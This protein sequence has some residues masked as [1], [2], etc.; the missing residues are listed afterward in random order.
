[1]QISHE[2]E[3]VIEDSN[4]I[5]LLFEKGSQLIK[6]FS[7]DEVFDFSLGNPVFEPPVEV[8]N[9]LLSLIDSNER[10]MHRYMPNQGIV[11]TRSYIA[12][13]LLKKTKLNFTENEV[14]ITTGAAGALNVLFKAICNPGDEVIVF[15]PYFIDYK[16]YVQNA[17]GKLKVVY[18]KSDF[19][20]DLEA[21]EKSINKMTK[22]VLINSPNNPTG[23]IYPKSD[24]DKMGEILEQKSKEYGNDIYLIS[25]S[26][27][28]KIVYDNI[29]VPSIFNSYKNSI[30][31][32]SYSKSLAIPGERIGH[33]AISPEM[34]DTQ[35]FMQALVISQRILG[36]VN[37][38][39]LFQRLIPK[40]QDVSVDLSIYKENRDELY[41]CITSLG[42]ECNKAAGAFYLFPKSPI[43]DDVEFVTEAQK[44]N[45]LLVPGSGFGMPG[46]FRI[47]YCVDIEKI[48]KSFSIFKNL[49]KKYN[50]I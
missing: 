17:G 48:K 14:I 7:E 22:A 5:K 25:D 19:Q 40:V 20:I 26:P 46:Y 23:I 16:Y 18:T 6:E 3:K 34:E 12:K 33:M 49:A 30:Y 32:Y 2:L 8:K 9:S 15:A 36:Y 21:F 10:G 50:L 27:Y 11:E 1:M 43:K 28:E 47:S 42:F 39:A 13:E 38:P 35:S 24:L 44:L 37:A 29:D 45:L 31:I 41:E 4:W